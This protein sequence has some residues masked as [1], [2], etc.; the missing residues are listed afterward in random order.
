MLGKATRSCVRTVGSALPAAGCAL[1][2]RYPFSRANCARAACFQPSSSG[3]HSTPFSFI[4]PV[5]AA[6]SALRNPGIED[7]I[8]C[9]TPP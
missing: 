4:H 2:N 1:W 3:P 6:S 5:K 7:R 9:A 8:L